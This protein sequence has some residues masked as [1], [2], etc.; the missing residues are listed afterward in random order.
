MSGLDVYAY[1]MVSKSTLY[2][3]DGGLP[4]PD[5]YAEFAHAF[6][7]IGGE[8]ANSSI[9]LSRLGVKVRLDGNWLGG[10]NGGE[11][12]LA[13][14]R[15]HGVDVTRLRLD[16]DY[17]GVEEVVIAADDTRTILGTYQKLFSAGPQ[18][19]APRA[20]DVAAARVVSLDPFFREESRAVA[21]LCRELGKPWVTIDCRWDDELATGAAVN[22]V[23]GEFRHRELPG[24][25]V[26]ELLARYQA[27]ASGLVVFTQGGDDV[28]YG[29]RGE[30]ARR[31]PAYRIRPVDTAGAGDSFRAGM[32]YAVLRGLPDEAAVRF[33]AALAAYVCEVFPGVLRC[34]TLAELEA[35]LRARGEDGPVPAT[36]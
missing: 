24:R 34:P 29:R 15:G 14:L 19:N 13:T 36:P 4:A 10:R 28:L 8:A 32:V 23:S 9:V 30:P 12:P 5:A 3:L 35:W 17:A 33:S 21:R 26:E 27:A 20:E 6:D 1:G 18:W 7:Q 11:R 16:P 22:V 25:D 31:L 2:K